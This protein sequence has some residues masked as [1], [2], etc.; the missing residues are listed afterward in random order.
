MTADLFSLGDLTA[1]MMGLVVVAAL[2]FCVS[3]CVEDAP[4]ISGLLPRQQGKVDGR[5]ER[6]PHAAEGAT[7]VVNTIDD[8]EVGAKRR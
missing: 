1:I 5:R 6:I 8:G 3:M 2:I 4:G 7:L